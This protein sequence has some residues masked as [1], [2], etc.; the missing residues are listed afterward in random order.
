MALCLALYARDSR[1]RQVPMG[2][3]ESEDDYKEKFKAEIYDEI[4]QELAKATPDEMF[5]PDELELL[6][7]GFD[8]TGYN[9]DYARAHDKLI[10][11][12]GWAIFLAIWLVNN[13]NIA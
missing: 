3:G 1:I 7:G 2:I 6:R 12:F 9:S 5:D 13:H 8:I 4:R 11:E 10:R